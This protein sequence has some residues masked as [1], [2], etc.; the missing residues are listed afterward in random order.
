MRING[1]T[2]RPDVE[3]PVQ[4]VVVALPTGMCS[5]ARSLLSRTAV[6]QNMYTS[7]RSKLFGSHGQRPWV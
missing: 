7:D 6:Q 3:G 2:T 4:T 5:T 1:L